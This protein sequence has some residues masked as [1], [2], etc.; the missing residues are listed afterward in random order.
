MSSLRLLN[1]RCRWIGAFALVALLLSSCADVSPTASG[2]DIT[3]RVQGTVR[4][5]ASDSLM[6][7]AKVNIGVGL[8][9]AS[10]RTDAEGHYSLT[11]QLRNVTPNCS[12]RIWDSTYHLEMYVEA[13]GYP[14]RHSDGSDAAPRP[15]CTDE[16]QTLHFKLRK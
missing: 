16:P 3:L 6:P 14:L 1:R 7:N 15:H 9:V 5:L 13:E 12:G 11:L 10:V 2:I 4:D 8:T